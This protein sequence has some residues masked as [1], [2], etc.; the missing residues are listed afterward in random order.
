[1][2]PDDDAA[3]AQ[4]QRMGLVSPYAQAQPLPHAMDPVPVPARHAALRVRSFGGDE[5]VASSAS[6]AQRERHDP[7]RCATFPQRHGETTAHAPAAS[8]AAWVGGGGVSA[9]ALERALTESEYA[10]GGGGVG[11]ALPEFIG[12]GGGEGIFRV[13]LRAA[14]HPGRPPSL[15]VR[16]HPLR[17]TQVGAF[18]RTLA[19]D[20]RRRQLWAGAESGV[21]VWALDEAFDA[22]PGDAALRRGDEESAPFRES[23]PTPPAL[24]AAVDGANRLV[25]TGHKDGRIRAWRMDLA[26]AAGGGGGNATLFE[27]ALAWQAF[28]RTPVLAIVVTSY[29]EIWSGSEGGIIKAWPWDAIAKS[30]SLTSEEKHM[31]SL[32]I[33]KAYIDLRNHATVGNMSSLPAADVKHMLADHCQAKVWSI[34]SMRFALWDARTR[35]LLKVFGIDGQVDLARLEAPVMP[36]QFIEEEIKVKPTKK[37]KP[38]G[39]FTF[40]QKSRNALIGAAD[41][42]RRA[43]TKGTFV[44]DNRRT[45]AVAQ[46]MD[47]TIWSGCTNGSIIVWDGSGNKLQEFQYH[48][49]SVRCIKALGERVWVGY[50]SGTIQVMDVEGNLLAEWTGH[51]C[52][53]ITMAIGGSHIFSL[54]HHGGIR[55][56]P[57]TSPSPLDDILRTELANRELS[58]T[59]IEN[60][61]ILVGTWNVAQEKASF[62]SLRS[63]LGSALTDV[64]LVVV[65]LQEVEMG[66]GVLAMAAAKESVGL[67][68]SAN[69][70]WWID[71]IGRTLDEGISFHRVGSR[72]LAGL[73]IGA[74]ARNDLKPHVGDVDAAAVPCGFG[75]AIGNKANGNQDDEDIPELAEADM[76]VFLGDFNYR[77]D[78]ITYDEA[79]DM[80]SQRSF[81]WLRERDQLRAEMKAG[82]VFQGMREGPI[83]FPPTYK[84]QRNQ[85]G[86]SGYDSSEKKRIPAWC[87]RIVYRDSRPVSIAECS[88]NCPVVASVTAYEACM[89]VTDSDHKPVRCTFSVDI[90]RVDELIRRQEFGKI[91]ESNI[92][93]RSFL[94]ESHVVPDTIVSTNNIILENQEDV[95]LRI[96]NNCETRKAAFEILCEAQSIT[97]KDGTKYEIPPRASFGFP[98]W[99]EVQPSVGLIE[100]GETMEVAVHHE[101]F[102][103]QEEFVDGVQQNWWCEATRDMVAVLLVNVTGSASTETITHRINVRH[104]CPVPSAPP[105]VKPR[106][107]TDAPS[108]NVSGSK[109]NQSNH[110]QRSDFANFGSSEVHDLC[111]VPKLNM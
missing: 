89:D 81:D 37:E 32:L 74:W 80:V 10:A 39:S 57:L 101:D 36:E 76:V 71:N 58:Y 88:L 24:C 92:E 6:A 69:G 2:E 108:D 4:P 49:S 7:A 53:V 23:V 56:W 1:M 34:T 66:A 67:E 62:E 82:N 105:P 30:L 54:A 72:Q 68:G 110:L 16:P 45:E 100:P 51:S 87:D 50:A 33:E 102:F 96:S 12:A 28:S 98:L 84:F 38:Q 79:R 103:T 94:W 75:R 25:W 27:E 42:V 47:G 3:P 60:I 31:A 107:I 65:G 43:A 99:L 77:L 9:A 63:W 55:G 85:P 19:C 13:P 46:A 104:C 21:R 35:E 17:E 14:M 20:P 22:W 8:F 59:K 41:A 90:A 18:L 91:I 64:G 11:G 73:L 61:K 97:N 70:Q 29:G 26:T 106:S 5:P 111:G 93:V 83:R 109:N 95:I 52:P 15:E 48:S 78:G 40:F 86:L 44:E